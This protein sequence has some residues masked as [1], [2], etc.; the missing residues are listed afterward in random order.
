MKVNLEVVY[1]TQTVLKPNY[2]LFYENSLYKTI[3]QD[4]NSVT[5]QE[6]LT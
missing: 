2:L 6:Y 3:E 4:G 1:T 5:I